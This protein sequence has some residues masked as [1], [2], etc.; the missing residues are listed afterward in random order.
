MY[1]CRVCLILR[2]TI[3]DFTIAIHA[4]FHPSQKHLVGQVVT[5]EKIDEAAAVYEAH[6]GPG[7]F[8]YDGNYE[9]FAGEKNC[10]SQL[11]SLQQERMNRSLDSQDFIFAKIIIIITSRKYKIYAN[12]ST[13]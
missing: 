4:Y 2:F 1:S 5:K 6:L 13:R 9:Y 3:H 7:L 11:P 12:E 10:P 8:N